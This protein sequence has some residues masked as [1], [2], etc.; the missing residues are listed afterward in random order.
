[1]SLVTR[2][3]AAVFAT[4]ALAAGAQA[5]D[6]RV[7]ATMAQQ[8]E[9]FATPSLVVERGRQ[10]RASVD[11]HDP[12]ALALTLSP[13]EG[14]A[15]H[16]AADLQSARGSMAPEVIVRPGQPAS[17]AVDGLTLTLTADPVGG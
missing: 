8:G 13:A 14:G 12:Y 2:S 1:M 6:H 5:Q 16:V 10:A 4:T 17:V 3:L 11:G 9:V 15:V 7:T